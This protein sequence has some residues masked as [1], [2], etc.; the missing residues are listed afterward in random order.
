MANSWSVTTERLTS[1]ANVLEEK[2]ARYNTEWAKLYTEVE[3]LKSTQW[4]GVASDAFNSKLESYRNDFEELANVLNSYRDFLISAAEVYAKTED[5]VKD[6]AG[7]LNA[8][9]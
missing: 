7:N 9:A 2:I 8:G 5:A 3:N 4:Q 6:A 1:S